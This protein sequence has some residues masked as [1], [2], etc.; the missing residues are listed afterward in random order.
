MLLWLEH[1]GEPVC[2]LDSLTYAG[3]LE[4]LA[5]LKGDRRFN[6]VQGDVCDGAQIAGL[7]SSHRPRAIV[8]FAA[9]SH[10]D[11][12]ILGPA[13]F[14]RTNVTGTFVLLQEAHAYYAVFRVLSE[15]NFGFS[16]FQR[17]RYTGH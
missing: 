1:V 9:E 15:T 11:R 4:S 17:T 3:N 13:D 12:S 5:D 14:M 10:V 2:V 16:M 6:F 8:H 7:L